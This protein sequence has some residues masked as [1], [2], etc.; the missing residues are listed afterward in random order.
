MTVTRYF[1]FHGVAYNRA[2]HPKSG[3]GFFANP[4]IP[5][6]QG[7][8]PPSGCRETTLDKASSQRASSALLHDS[9]PART[10]ILK[11]KARRRVGRRVSS[12]STLLT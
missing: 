11:N 7:D 4:V 1:C 3:K 2:T 8:H 10:G 9:S 12:S 5:S 6:D